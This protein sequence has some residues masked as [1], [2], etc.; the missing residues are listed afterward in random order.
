VPEVVFQAQVQRVDV[1]TAHQLISRGEAVLV[2]AR[3]P[4]LFQQKHLPDAINIPA[5]LFDILYPMKLGRMLKPEQTVLVY[6]RTISKRY[7]DDVAQR[8]LQRHEHIKVVE[9]GM[10]AW[11]EKGLPVAP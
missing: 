8:L 11:E 1:L 10:G 4:E 9:G 7:D 2:D 6:G 5:A 3:P